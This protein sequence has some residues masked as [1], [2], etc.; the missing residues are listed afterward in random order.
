MRK[1]HTNSGYI[2]LSDVAFMTRWK[3][4][5]FLRCFADRD[6]LTG[7]KVLRNV[8]TG[9]GPT[10]CF[11]IS[12]SILGRN[13]AGGWGVAAY[14]IELLQVFFTGELDGGNGGTMAENYP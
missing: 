8:L 11:L 10:K 13:L 9:I 14:F 7:R 12:E 1:E 3:L 2:A 4:E 6:G 5:S